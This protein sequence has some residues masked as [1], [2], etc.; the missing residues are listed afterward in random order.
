MKKYIF[1]PLILVVLALLFTSP[2]CRGQQAD[3][4]FNYNG[5]PSSKILKNWKKTVTRQKLD[6]TRTVETIRYEDPETK[7]AVA[8]ITTTY[9]DFPA[10]H[11]ILCFRNAGT[12]DT[13][14]ISEIL[15]LDRVYTF[16]EG[17]FKLSYAEGSH[18]RL[19][20]FRP[21]EQ[22]LSDS[23]FTIKPDNGRPSD[24]VMPYFNVRNGTGAGMAFAIGWSGQWKADFAA[25][26]N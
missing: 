14:I 16:P 24:E 12:E 21:K 22:A 17:G 4:S 6:A 18:E 10:K 25:N 9:S 5:Q 26:G 8:V 3:F 1:A 7:L 19:T 13:G 20:D 23:V 2:T 15:P 11:T